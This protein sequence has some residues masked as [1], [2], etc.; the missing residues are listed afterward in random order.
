MLETS[1]WLARTFKPRID[2][3]RVRRDLHQARLIELYPKY[4]DTTI[5]RWQ[6][7]SGRTATLDGKRDRRRTEAAA[8]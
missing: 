3:G 6:V 8:A 2:P 7:F 1:R 5:L 4:A